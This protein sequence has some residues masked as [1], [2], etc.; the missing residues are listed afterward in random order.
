MQAVKTGAS[1]E[2]ELGQHLVAETPPPLST[3]SA[4]QVRTVMRADYTSLIRFLASFP[5]ETRGE[6]FWLRRFDLWW[7]GNPAFHEGVPRGWMLSEDGAINGFLGNVPTQVQ[8]FGRPV[9]AFSTTTWRVLPSHRN[10]SLR[11]FYQ[12]LRAAKGS[13]FF[14]AT[15]SDDAVRILESLKFQLLPHLA[16]P[17]KS[18]VILN[19]ERVLRSRILSKVPTAVAAWLG[20]PI[21]R[22]FQNHRLH[23]G[24]KPNGTEVQH[25]TRADSSFDELWLQTR[26]LYANTN[27][28]SAAVINWQ[29]FANEDFRKFLFG[30]FR[31]E[32]LV[33]YV[34]VASRV[35]DGLRVLACLDIWLDPDTPSALPELLRY[36][37]NW[38]REGGFD[39]IEIPHYDRSL[40]R[41]LDSLGLFQRNAAGEMPAYYKIPESGVL[42][43]AASFFVGL[44]GDRGL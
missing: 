5:E 11:L 23:L 36:V 12:A 4:I 27:V 31:A 7:D 34:I 21:L 3:R 26:Q 42:D 38:S 19:P 20:A 40:E 13:I 18:L 14:D 44:Q 10:H 32:R 1:S 17:R 41:R 39:L 29:C 25:L 16:N 43:P 30:C 9:I 6:D 22:V 35:R 28:R 24:T 33:G 2:P 37:W 15:P 8:L